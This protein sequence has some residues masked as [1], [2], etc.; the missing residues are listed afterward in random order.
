MPTRFVVLKYEKLGVVVM[1]KLFEIFFHNYFIFA[2]KH[3]EV[4]GVPMLFL[5]K[6][7]ADKI[8]ISKLQ[9]TMLIFYCTQRCT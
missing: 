6:G 4:V 1:K 7:V 9:N 5:P 2:S 3:K 8:E